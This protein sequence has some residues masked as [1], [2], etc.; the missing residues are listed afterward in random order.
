VV[1]RAEHAGIILRRDGHLA[2]TEEGRQ[3]ARQAIMK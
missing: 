1:T 2:L 3:V